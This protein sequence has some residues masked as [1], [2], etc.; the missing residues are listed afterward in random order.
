MS[1]DSHS[2]NRDIA[3]EPSVEA[4]AE[5][6]SD[7]PPPDSTSAIPDSDVS[8]TSSTSTP[9]PPAEAPST[10]APDPTLENFEANG[11]PDSFVPNPTDTSPSDSSF[12]PVPLPPSQAPQYANQQPQLQ[13]PGPPV[14]VQARNPVL[15]VVI[16]FL[17]TG[18]GLMVQGRV[19]LGLLFLGTNILVSFF[20]F[21]PVLGWILFFL[22]MIPIWI[23]SMVMA[24]GTAKNWNRQHGI[25]S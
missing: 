4:P 13:Q 18:L 20:L 10:E 12:A 21:I 8:E 15:Y 23:I 24:F 22:V 1:P 19:G 16:D 2:S 14:Q 7:P 6:P 5:A 25:I 3:Q 11:S 17:I 9:P